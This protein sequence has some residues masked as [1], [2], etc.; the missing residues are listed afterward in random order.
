MGVAQRVSRWRSRVLV[1]LVGREPS[2][3][4]KSRV[5]AFFW[6]VLKPS[7]FRLAH[8]HPRASLPSLLEEPKAPSFLLELHKPAEKVVE[9]VA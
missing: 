7:V 3:R 1:Q 4:K 2:L 5:Q 9:V 6:R 8:Y